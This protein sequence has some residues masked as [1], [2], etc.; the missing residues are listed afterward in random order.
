ML[1][2]INNK[3]NFCIYDETNNVDYYLQ[4]TDILVNC[5]NSSE[6]FPNI[7]GEAIS[8]DCL[9]ISSGIGEAKRIF[10]YNENLFKDFI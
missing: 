1:Q 9:C 3:D 8:S 7:I 6:G 4:K 2:K 10:N 5:S